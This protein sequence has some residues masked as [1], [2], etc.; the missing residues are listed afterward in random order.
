[1]SNVTLVYETLCQQCGEDTSK[2][3]DWHDIIGKNPDVVDLIDNLRIEYCKNPQIDIFGIFEA[4]YSGF[5]NNL[6]LEQVKAYAKTKYSVQQMNVIRV[7]FQ[8]GLNKKQF[9]VLSYPKFSPE[10]MEAIAWCILN[11]HLSETEAKMF[12]KKEFS[13]KQIREIFEGFS[14]GLSIED[15]SIYADVR[16]NPEQMGV[17][18]EGL[19]NTINYYGIKRGWTKERVMFYAKPEICCKEM[20]SIYEMLD[21]GLTIDQIKKYTDKKLSHDQFTQIAIGFI[22]D[23]LSEEQVDIYADEKF[24]SKQMEQIRISFREKIPEEVIRCFAKPNVSSSK[25]E[26]IRKRISEGSSLEEI[27][28]ELTFC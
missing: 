4:I 7:A 27:K 2:F 13:P 28:K 9:R 22:T 8:N 5:K 14:E 1:M 3:N 18:R 19:F 24:N 11:Y 6:S 20:M 21:L 25:M 16:F 17:I 15:I 12:A 10:Q 23:R 26:T